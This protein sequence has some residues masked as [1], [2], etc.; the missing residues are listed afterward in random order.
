L[1][2]RA[3]LDLAAQLL[4]VEDALEGGGVVAAL[5]LL[6]EL[7]ALENFDGLVEAV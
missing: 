5:A 1:Q 7:L 4:E 2:E 6:G 3:L